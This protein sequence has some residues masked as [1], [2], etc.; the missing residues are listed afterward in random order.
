MLWSAS[1]SYAGSGC[2]A[3]V[4]S[5]WP[6]G[7]RAAH[8][9]LPAERLRPERHTQGRLGRGSSRPR[10]RRRSPGR[11][12]SSR[13]SRRR[14]HRGPRRGAIDSPPRHRP[15]SRCTPRR[16]PRTPGALRAA[17]DRPARWTRPGARPIRRVRSTRRRVRPPAGRAELRSPAAVP[18]PR[19][20]AAGPRHPDL[21]RPR[22]RDRRARRLSSRGRSLKRANGRRTFGAILSAADARRRQ[23]GKRPSRRSD[24][25][26]RGALQPGDPVPF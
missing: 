2:S 7:G 10:T 13:P 1:S 22:S 9:C 19:R 26:G 21:D 25:R 15:D 16:V 20:H 3:P 14:P 23:P 12:R 8:G 4:S 18:Q 17:T 6:R 11:H 24:V 5:A